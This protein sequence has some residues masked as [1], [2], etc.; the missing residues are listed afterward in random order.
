MKGIDDCV[1]S[2]G[3]PQSLTDAIKQLPETGRENAAGYMHRL[4]RILNRG[5]RP[6]FFESARPE[7][8][9]DL[10]NNPPADD[11][12]IEALQ[13]HNL[14]ATEAMAVFVASANGDLGARIK[15]IREESAEGNFNPDSRA[16]LEIRWSDYWSRWHTDHQSYWRRGEAMLSLEEFANLPWGEG[17]PVV[18][19]AKEERITKACARECLAVYGLVRSV[20]ERNNPVLV[21]GNMRY[22]G[23]FVVKPM[24]RQLKEAGAEVM[25]CYVR[26]ADRDEDYVRMSL[27]DAEKV[28]QYVTVKLPDVVVVDGT[29]T[30][31]MYGKTRLPDS[32]WGYINLFDA[33][34]ATHRGGSGRSDSTKPKPSYS[35]R[36]WSPDMTD[37]VYVGSY[38]FDSGMHASGD[39]ELVLASSIGMCDDSSDAAFDDANVYIEYKIQVLCKYGVPTYRPIAYSETSFVLEVQKRI[40]LEF[41]T[42]LSSSPLSP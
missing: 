13:E 42:L 26:S 11:F 5:Y 22:G 27:P 21:I 18:L 14:P 29:G 39:R 37:K 16:H 7:F 4:N 3:K 10:L 9:A 6:L 24:E 12:L 40:A 1:E 38:E 33:W 2:L 34:N 32:M 28:L 25:Y 23:N 35:M 17:V 36:P 15:S 41:E 20:L 31:K 8:L 19:T 30:C